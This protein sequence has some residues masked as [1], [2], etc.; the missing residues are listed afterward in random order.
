MLYGPSY[1]QR[2]YVK[3]VTF[4]VQIECTFVKQSQ[5]YSW[6][7]CILDKIKGTPSRQP[8]L[9]VCLWHIFSY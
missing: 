2:H 9:S 3:Y 4:H 1:R 8:A 5:K 6:P 7:L